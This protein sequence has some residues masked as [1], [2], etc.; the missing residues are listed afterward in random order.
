MVYAFGV[1]KPIDIVRSPWQL[2][3]QKSFPCHLMVFEKSDGLKKSK[4]LASA[5]RDMNKVLVMTLNSRKVGTSTI[6][7]LSMNVLPDV[8]YEK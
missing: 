3:S 8:V 7:E 1:I 5:R 2:Q 4:T 6:E